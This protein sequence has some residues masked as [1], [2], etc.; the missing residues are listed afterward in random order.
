MSLI[1]VLAAL[2]LHFISGMNLIFWG[3]RAMRHFLVFNSIVFTCCCR[4]LVQL[5]VKWSPHK[6]HLLSSERCR[7][8]FQ[9]RVIKRNVPAK[10][11]NCEPLRRMNVDD[12]SKA[13]GVELTVNEWASR[14]ELCS[15]HAAP[16]W[17]NLLIWWP[18]VAI[19]GCK[20]RWCCWWWWLW[21]LNRLSSS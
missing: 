19:I 9:F 1:L 10:R 8:A 18:H 17:A 5:C 2:S 4:C 11:I 6:G 20:K 16:V 13:S 3:Q 15:K 12:K 14:V 21:T 7:N